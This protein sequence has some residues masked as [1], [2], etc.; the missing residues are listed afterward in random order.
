MTHDAQDAA[1]VVLQQLEDASMVVVANDSGESAATATATMY[2]VTTVID[3]ILGADQLR[4]LV[5][6]GFLHCNRHQSNKHKWQEPHL[7]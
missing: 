4:L 5:L 2:L 1:S 3:G 6:P 7:L